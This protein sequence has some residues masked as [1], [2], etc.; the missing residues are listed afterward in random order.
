MPGSATREKAL[1]AALEL[2]G[3]K[4]YDR[5]SMNDIA[6][7]VGIRAP[8]LY[9]HFA[10][11]EALFAATAPYV[12]EHYQTLWQDAANAQAVLEREARGPGALSAERLE[13]TTMPWVMAELEDGVGFRAFAGQV[14]E[15]LDWLWDRPL[16][17]Y[18]GF[19]SRL[20]E[21]QAVKRAD[22]HTMALEYLAPILHLID[23]ADRD[24]S[25]RATAEEDIR[26]HVRQFCRAFAVKERSP[27]S[28]GVRSLFR[29]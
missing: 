20:M 25:R 5:V 13:L 2:F 18:E 26:K 17:L 29:R 3:R 22:A 19:F 6:E 16:T 21:R 9:K 1:Q 24:S 4:G 12:R 14:A 15:G 10:G 8:S 27:A 11:K 28:G 7:A 23:L